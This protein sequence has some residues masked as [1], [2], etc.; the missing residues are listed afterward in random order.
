VGS[1]IGGYV[2]AWI[3]GQIQT[4]EL[5]EIL[6]RYDKARSK[7]IAEWELF[8]KKVFRKLVS[9]ITEETSLRFL[10]Y[11][12]IEKSIELSS[13]GIDCAADETNPNLQ[14]ALS[15]FD[16]AILINSGRSLIWNFR[17]ITLFESKRFEEAIIAFNQVLQIDFNF[18][19]AWSYRGASLAN[20]ERYEEAIS[21]Y[22]KALS[23][24]SN[25]FFIW[26]DQGEALS[27]LGR[28]QGEHLN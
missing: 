15:F 3:G 28:Y 12:A 7:L 4:K 14:K 26:Y 16:Q 11:E 24:E 6:T 13:K 18:Y 17:G 21:C 20:L 23:I 1:A 9:L 19:K 22:E 10:T 27:N 5:Q 8:L 2:G 25:D